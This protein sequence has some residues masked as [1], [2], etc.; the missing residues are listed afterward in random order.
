MLATCGALDR[1]NAVRSS[2]FRP[3]IRQ[4]YVLQSI[5]VMPE[6][7]GTTDTDLRRPL[8]GEEDSPDPKRS[9]PV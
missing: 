3:L 7:R 4:A 8:L 5:I 2:N 6:I 9:A 1:G